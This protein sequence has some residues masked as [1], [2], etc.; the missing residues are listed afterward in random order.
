MTLNL[1]VPKTKEQL[2][3]RITVVG[4]GGAGDPEGGAPAILDPRIGVRGAHG[5]VHL[6]ALGPGEGDQLLEGIA[7]GVRARQGRRGPAIVPDRR[8]LGGTHAEILDPDEGRR[9]FPAFR[10]P[11]AA[12]VIHDGTAALVAAEETLHALAERAAA[13]GATLRENVSVANWTPGE[14]GVEVE[15]SEGHLVADR[16]IVAKV[17]RQGRGRKRRHDAQRIQIAVVA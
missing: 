10:F 5:E 17:R 8:A 6:G 3:P 9:R 12:K 7:Q 13:E 16:V 2:S 1:N 11:D 15:T 4:V 14:D